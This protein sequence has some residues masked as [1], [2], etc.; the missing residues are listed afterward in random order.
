MLKK[1]QEGLK[2]RALDKIYLEGDNK[3]MSIEEIKNSVAALADEYNISKVIL[4]GSRASGNNRADSDIDLIVEFSKPVSLLKLSALK[5]RLE[6]ITGFSVDII[7][8]PLRDDD[9]IE[10]DNEV[11]LYA[12]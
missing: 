7:H 6:E 11:V 2:N 4:F 8:G 5:N 3:T 12:A 1:D 10:I 9:M